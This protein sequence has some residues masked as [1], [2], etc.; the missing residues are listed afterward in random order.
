MQHTD[1]IEK[2]L[3]ERKI[4]LMECGAKK[5]GAGMEIESI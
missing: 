3:Y 1:P 4:T 2:R 5:E